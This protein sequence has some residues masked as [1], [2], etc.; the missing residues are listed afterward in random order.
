MLDENKLNKLETSEI[1]DLFELDLTKFNLGIFRFTS[2]LSTNEHGNV[3]TINFNNEFYL[4]APVSIDGF[5]KSSESLPSLKF[6]ISNIN[7]SIGTYIN[8]YDDLIG[9]NLKIIRVFKENLDNENNQNF[10]FEEFKISKKTDHNDVFI[11][12]ELKTNIDFTNIKLP[13]R[14]VWKTY[15]SRSYRKYVNG[16][17]IYGTCP[18]NENIYFDVNNIN[19]QNSSEDK[20][21]KTPESCKKRFNNDTLLG[22]F[23]PG[24]RR[25]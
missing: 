23:F 4:P 3:K 25:Q 21:G 24:I 17:F 1:I 19:R 5:E 6:R 7:N 8:N 10:Q 12:F 9:I 15:C 11:E 13:N 14:Q 18:Y 22:W 20:C 2:H 16:K